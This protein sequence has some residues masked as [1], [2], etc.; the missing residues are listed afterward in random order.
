M[1]RDTLSQKDPG[2]E[3][4]PFA[5]PRSEA[6]RLINLSSVLLSEEKYGEAAEMLRT[7]IRYD[8][9][10]PQ[11]YNNLGIA[12]A[13]LGDEEGAKEAFSRALELDPS[14]SS[15]KSNLNRMKEEVMKEELMSDELR[16]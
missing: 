10:F 5:P 4:F 7:A 1:S 15:A 6:V 12:L 13:E 14:N 8:D 9:S 2:K 3:P 11:A 16:K